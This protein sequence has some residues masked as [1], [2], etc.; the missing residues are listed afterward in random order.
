MSFPFHARVR[1]H[2]FFLLATFGITPQECL[3]ARHRA[4]PCLSRDAPGTREVFGRA[5]HVV[6]QLRSLSRLQALKLLVMAAV[7]LRAAIQRLVTK[8]AARAILN[9]K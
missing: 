4:A 5:M 7:N 6:E 2:L 3:S 1:Q 9:K 8:L